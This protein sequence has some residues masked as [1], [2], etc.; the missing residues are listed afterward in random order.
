M[1]V[2]HMEQARGRIARLRAHGIE[3]ALDDFG[4]G[5]SSLNMLRSLPLHTVKID[6]SPVEPL[7]APDATAVVKAICDR[8][9]RSSS[10]SSPREWKPRRSRRRC[11]PPAAA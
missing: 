2:A 7:P 8:P 4:T 5:F 10:T 11:A 1:A 6:R 3:V 9:A